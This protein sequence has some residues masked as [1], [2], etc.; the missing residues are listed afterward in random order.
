MTFLKMPKQQ[1]VQLQPGLSKKQA[2][3]EAA[4]KAKHDWRGIKYN[5][6]TGRAQLT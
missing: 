5:K 3:K 4:K 6:K 1:T 2:F